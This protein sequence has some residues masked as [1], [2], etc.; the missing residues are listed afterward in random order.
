MK[1]TIKSSRL[2]PSYAWIGNSAITPMASR[3]HD[4]EWLRVFRLD[5]A[6]FAMRSASTH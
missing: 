6:A 1:K 3:S 4:E 2:R 5:L